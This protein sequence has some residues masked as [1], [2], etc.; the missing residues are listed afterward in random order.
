[1]CVCV[2]VCVCV[3]FPDQWC[4]CDGA[5]TGVCA[6][7]CVCV[8]VCKFLLGGIAV[9]VLGQVCVYVFV[10]ACVGVCV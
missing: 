7:V 2:G 9:M 1:V 4:C 5:W 3:W 6:C 10:C 8:C